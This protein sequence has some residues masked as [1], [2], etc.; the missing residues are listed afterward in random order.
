MIR[1][2]D[3]MSGWSAFVLMGHKDINAWSRD[4]DLGKICGFLGRMEECCFIIINY[5]RFMSKICNL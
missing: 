4:W 1:I 2:P 5:W 3:V